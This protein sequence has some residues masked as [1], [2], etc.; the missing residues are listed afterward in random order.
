M[1]AAKFQTRTNYPASTS[2][3]LRAVVELMR[4]NQ[5]FRFVILAKLCLLIGIML[6]AAVS[7]NFVKQ[8]LFLPDE[9]L[10]RL[11]HA[12]A[13]PVAI[14]LGIIA[15]KWFAGN[16]PELGL[17]PPGIGAAIICTIVAA[18]FPSKIYQMTGWLWLLPSFLIFILCSGFFLGI[19]FSQLDGWL[20]WFSAHGKGTGKII[21][22][23]NIIFL[24]GTILAVITAIFVF[25]INTNPTLIFFANG[26]FLFLSSAYIFRREPV[27]MIQTIQLLLTH[28][29]HYLRVY[30]R[31]NIPNKGAVL[32]IANHVSFI[33][34]FLIYACTPRR[35]H[36]MMHE[37]FYRYPIFHSLVKWAGFI[38][39]PEGKPH[40][41]RQMFET[42]N[43]LLRAGEVLC[44]FPE[45][46]VTRNG[47][48]SSFKKGITAMS[49]QDIEVAF[50]PV[51][52]GMLW[53]SIFTRYCGKFKLRLP[54]EIPHPACITIGKP[55]PRDTPNYKI[56]QKLSEMAAA[57][58]II[59]DSKELPLHA[60][61]VKFTRRHPFK[62]IIKEY[63]G[64]V[65]REYINFV[66][67]VR[68]VLLSREI[69]RLTSTADTSPYVG[70]MLPNG[71][72]TVITLLAIQLADKTPAIL[73]FTASQ[74]A[75]RAAI[76][77]AEIKY[78]FT[79]RRFL[80]KL[81]TDP[82]PEMVFLEDIAPTISRFRRIYFAVLAGILPW[83]V[84]IK[85]MSPLSYN[86]V[87]RTGAV[88][89][90]SGST[91]IPKGV[92][93]SH[94]NINSNLFSF[95]RIMNWR[96]T[97]KVIGNLPVFHSFGLTVCLWLPITYGAEVVYVMNP[98]DAQSVGYV[99]K[100]NQITVMVATPG[101]LQAYMRR[102]QPD[103]F[104]SLRLV[105][106][107]A[108]KLRDDIA[109]KFFEITGLS[110]AEGY[111]CSELS[112]VVSINVANSTVDI[113]TQV[114]QPGSVG[115]AMPGICVKIV[116]PETFAPLP[117]EHDG[118]LLVK[119]ANV[120]QGY[121]ND[122]EATAKVIRDG[123]YITGDIGKM[124]D[125]GYITITG[126]LSRFSKIAGEMIPHEL[127]EKE[128]NEF[129]QPESLIIAVT[130]TKDPRK[131][132][133]LIVFYSDPKLN[134]EAVV[135]ALRKR[136]LPNL[137]IPRP[138]NFIFIEKIP[139]LGSG[140]LNL[141]ELQSI[142]ESGG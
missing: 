47:I 102:C 8:Q 74:A 54:K 83:R 1:N 68:S 7:L 66:I 112:P 19:A 43:Q 51:R 137:W 4:S 138:E 89:F 34:I 72:G 125:N 50:I 113:G 100:H 103:D 98:L 12:L 61:F 16:K 84:L 106:T 79:S 59:P 9:E 62:K 82:L 20:D 38:E 116:H 114:G 118:L 36:F 139:M 6:F 80:K 22:G 10:S 33:D 29:V 56:R 91:G 135:T 77:K 17:I 2:N 64:F 142:V 24:S 42:T 27:F 23:L 85:I 110:I 32:L 25:K 107:G 115:A 45:G 73:N 75:I 129:L 94:H 26:I 11:I 39:V 126:R 40:K 81:N 69:R 28:T 52:L 57:T 123:W 132:E 30:G 99:L 90:S 130:G 53:G 49:P 95:I 104:A 70:M 76:D 65:Q 44:V 67:L 88:I 111:G 14:I 127:V 92:K 140:K 31:E 109:A 96:N 108:E 97:D 86:D 105:V 141:A 78:L 3:S 18:L 93:L 124:N 133:K 21:P 63:D 13:L 48:M 136:H 117:P 37:S 41:L 119:G 15:G 87:H 134:P 60:R 121:L 55:I 120:M 58:E 128:I 5:L 35:V 101:F 46:G 71:V 122:P 131:G